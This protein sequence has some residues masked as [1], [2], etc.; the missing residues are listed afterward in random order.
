MNS[1]RGTYFVKL[2]VAQLFK[3]FLTFYGTPSL[4][5]VF[6]KARQSSLSCARL[7]KDKGYKIFSQDTFYYYPLSF[8][9][10]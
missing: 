8:L 3:K 1:L 9:R 6:T 4:I 2:K 10:F 5:T 7:I